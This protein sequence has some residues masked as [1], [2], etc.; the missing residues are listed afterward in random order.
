MNKWK[1]GVVFAAGVA[2]GAFGMIALQTGLGRNSRPGGEILVLPMVA[3]LLW[4]GWCLGRSWDTF[5]MMR[6]TATDID[7][8]EYVNENLPGYWSGY[9]D[10]YDDALETMEFSKPVRS[11]PEKKRRRKDRKAVPER[12]KGA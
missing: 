5:Q 8:E 7:A 12:R 4:A 1:F 10:G 9:S 6:A 11:R 2:A 3:L